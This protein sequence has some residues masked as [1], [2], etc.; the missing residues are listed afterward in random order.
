MTPS[1]PASS[2]ETPETSRTR[3]RRGEGD[4]L[5]DEILDAAEHLLV[6][7]GNMDAVSV[8][9]IANAVGCTPPAI[10]LH[11]T[12]KDDLFFH[13]CT[14]RFEE[15][16]Q[17][18]EGAAAGIDDVEAAMLAMG[19]A[20]VEYGVEHPEA[21]RVLFGVKSESLIPE[22]VDPADLPGMQAFNLL[23]DLVARGM[24]QGIFAG[25][26]PLS[27]SI[28]IWATMHGLVMLMDGHRDDDKIVIP[29]DIV[30]HVCEQAMQGLRAR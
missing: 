7:V 12:D 14:R 8:R 9:K 30:D 27:A 28:G 29:D 2:T 16:E 21:Y 23:V 20:Y 6:E 15:F 10:Y 19:R 1:T 25:P 11:F 24:E 22:G 13:V 26:D 4:R 17:T 18:L 3:A 5:R